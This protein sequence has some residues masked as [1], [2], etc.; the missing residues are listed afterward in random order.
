MLVLPG[1][2]GLLRLFV[3][4]AMHTGTAPEAPDKVLEEASQEKESVQGTVLY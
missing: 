4:P 1:S 2:A 3:P